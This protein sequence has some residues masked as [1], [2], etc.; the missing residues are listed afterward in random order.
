MK[1]DESWERIY[2]LQLITIAQILGLKHV[3]KTVRFYVTTAQKRHQGCADPCWRL[4]GTD[5][6]NHYHVDTDKDILGTTEWAHQL[7]SHFG[8]ISFE[9]WNIKDKLLA[10]LFAAGKKNITRK[11]FKPE[12]P[13]AE[14]WIE[15]VHNIYVLEKLSFTLKGHID[16]VCRIWF[17]WTEYIEPVKSDRL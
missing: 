12:A 3:G 2:E 1:K 9:N 13:T 15:I 6:A 10:I 8:N 7:L 17:K 11:W 16:T 5:N 14:E 4:C